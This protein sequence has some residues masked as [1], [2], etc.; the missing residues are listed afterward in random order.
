MGLG[1][2]CVYCRSR[3]HQP[4]L[5]E[6]DRY[7]EKMSVLQNFWLLPTQATR[8]VWRQSNLMTRLTTLGTG[9]ETAPAG[10]ILAENAGGREKEFI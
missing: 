1:R 6:Q 4:L 8:S 2:S 10:T 9:V 3:Q 5:W 7:I